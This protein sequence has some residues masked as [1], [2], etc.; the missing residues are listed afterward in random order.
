M[1]Y[2]RQ[3]RDRML[4]ELK[5]VSSTY[6]ANERRRRRRFLRMI[7]GIIVAVLLIGATLGF[8]YVWYMGKTQP[9][10]PAAVTKTVATT[11]PAPATP[12]VDENAPVGVAT[13][14]FSSQVPRGGNA[15]LSIRT[16]PQA[17]C[18]IRVT[19]STTPDQAKESKDGGLVPK[20][21]DMY[22]VASWTWTVEADRPGGAWPVEITCA[23]KAQWGYGK[24]MLQVID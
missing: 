8:A 22:G 12:V 18:S 11:A 14:S 7:I 15:S 2:W 21:A 23:Y 1:L 20:T 13:Q 24:E 3:E 9:V 19:Y 5:G 17:A 16:R 4:K 6:R 10:Q